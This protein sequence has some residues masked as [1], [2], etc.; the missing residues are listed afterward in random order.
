[1]CELHVAVGLSSAAGTIDPV[2]NNGTGRYKKALRVL[3]LL[4]FDTN[5]Y[6]LYVTLHTSAARKVTNTSQ[7]YV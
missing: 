6:Y 5:I 3:L 1:M 4:S 7:L 2:E